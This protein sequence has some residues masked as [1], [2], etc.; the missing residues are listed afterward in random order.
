MLKYQQAFTLVEMAIVLSIMTIVL[1]M[2]VPAAQSYFNSSRLSSAGM[3]L[4]NDLGQA[5]N[6]AIKRNSRVLI[7]PRNAAGTDCS[8]T[9]NWQAGWVICSDLDAN[10]ACDASTAANPNPLVIRGALSTSLAL[11]NTS[12]ANATTPIHFN[13]NGTQGTLGGT[14]VLLTLSGIWDNAPAAKIFSIASTGSVSTP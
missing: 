2:A 12:A 11:S 4:R 10:D 13:A 14:T 1:A 7:C 3:Q 9:A 8:A 5:R 6:E